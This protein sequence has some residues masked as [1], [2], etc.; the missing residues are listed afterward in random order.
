MPDEAIARYTRR[1]LLYYARAIIATR[2]LWVESRTSTIRY[3]LVCSADKGH[4][5]HNGGASYGMSPPKALLRLRRPSLT[6]SRIYWS[7]AFAND[8]MLRHKLHIRR[9]G[10][11]IEMLTDWL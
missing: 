3:G 7:M 4:V 6:E 2:T 11:V 1:L 8:T 5:C 9:A 10:R